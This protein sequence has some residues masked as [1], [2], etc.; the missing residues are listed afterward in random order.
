M[1]ETE[2]KCNYKRGRFVCNKFCHVTKSKRSVRYLCKEHLEAQR[3]NAKNAAIR[4]A[5]SSE[6]MSALSDAKKSSES[7]SSCK[8]MQTTRLNRKIHLVGLEE[9]AVLRIA[10]KLNTISIRKGRHR[11]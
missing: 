8:R 5:S 3:R 6:S 2:K 1:V 11:F 7:K 10:T 9:G 4:L